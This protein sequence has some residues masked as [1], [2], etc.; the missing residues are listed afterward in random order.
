MHPESCF[1]LWQG[2]HVLNHYLTEQTTSSSE[3]LQRCILFIQ[4]A[5][6]FDYSLWIFSQPQF[7]SVC[8]NESE[9]SDTLAPLLAL[10]LACNFLLH[11]PEKSGHTV[12]IQN[13]L[14][15]RS[16]R[17]LVCRTAELSVWRQNHFLTRIHWKVLQTPDKTQK[18][19]F[20]LVEPMQELKS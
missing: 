9:I 11:C 17:S 10:Q 20:N 8:L 13:F 5:P 12:R 1:L 18:E 2:I 14:P 16:A 15:S 7:I 19:Y 6:C 3:D 4:K